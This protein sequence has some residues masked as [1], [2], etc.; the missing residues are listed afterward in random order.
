MIPILR[1]VLTTAYDKE[2]RDMR[3]QISRRAFL[4]YTSLATFGIAAAGCLPVE[5]PAATEPGAPAAE[6]TRLRRISYAVFCLK[7]KRERS[8]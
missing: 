2:H 3:P 4:R 6:P 7:K 1:D 5:V 8:G